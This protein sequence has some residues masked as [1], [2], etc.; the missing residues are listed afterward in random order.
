MKWRCRHVSKKENQKN[1]KKTEPEICWCQA[2]IP[3]LRVA[4]TISQNG[5]AQ[6]FLNVLLGISN[7]LYTKPA[8]SFLC[9]SKQERSLN[10]YSFNCNCEADCVCLMKSRKQFSRNHREGEN[11]MF[12]FSGLSCDECCS[13]G[14]DAWQ[15]HRGKGS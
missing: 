4:V 8:A 10:R 6:P 9:T 5:S 14:S 7:R 13:R 1:K 2:G 3:S 11:K 15:S 12:T